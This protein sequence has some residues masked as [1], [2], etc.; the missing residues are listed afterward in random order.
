MAAPNSRARGRSAYART[1]SAIP[2][3]ARTLI[4]FPTMNGMGEIGIVG[5]NA[6]IEASVYD[7]T[8]QNMRQAPTPIKNLL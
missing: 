2:T 7:A 5:V 1:A 6:A 4:V 8:G 3:R